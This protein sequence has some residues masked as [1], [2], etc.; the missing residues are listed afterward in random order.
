MLIS[1][2]AFSLLR[3]MHVNETHLFYIYEIQERRISSGNA[4]PPLR[5]VSARKKA[6]A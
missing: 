2:I 3:G 1:F 4:F 6:Y 5:A